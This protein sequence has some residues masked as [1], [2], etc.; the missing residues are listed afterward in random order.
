MS[1]IKTYKIED[2]EPEELKKIYAESEKDHKNFLQ[3]LGGKKLTLIKEKPADYSML[4][5]A[6]KE[7]TKEA[8]KSR[9]RENAIRR[10][11]KR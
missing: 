7:V 3:N 5:K 2:I 9:R 10:N 11:T 8:S 4:V 1:E 6:A